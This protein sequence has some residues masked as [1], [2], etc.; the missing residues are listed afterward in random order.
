MALSGADYVFNQIRVGGLEARR[1]DE[2]FPDELGIPGEE[3][4]G[5]GGFANASR[6]IPIV[7]EYARL[8]ERYCP[9][10]TLLTLTNPISLVQYAITRYTHI[11]TIGLCDAPVTLKTNLAKALKVPIDELFMDYVGMHHFGW[12]TGIWHAGK[13][14]MPQVLEKAA[15]IN[16]EVEP[17]IVQ[18]FGAIPG[19]YYNYLFHSDRMLARKKGKR[20]RAEELLEI[21]DEILEDYDRVLV[22]G[23]RPASLARRNARWYKAIVT[24]VLLALIESQ[25]PGFR[26]GFTSPGNRFILNISNGEIIPWLPHEAIIEVS[27]IIESGRVRPLAIGPVSPAVKTLIQSNCAYEMLA[28]EAIVERDRSKALRALLLNP[29]IHTYDQA[30]AVLERA[31]NNGDKMPS[32]VYI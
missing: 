15:E 24:P 11:N 16:P 13:D 8:I 18:A 5:P 25:Q 28:V 27:S 2:S 26:S 4:V 6:T 20:T 9:S 22:T 3:T 19:G 30:N 23:Q 29:M 17:A 12:V 32:K 1:F 31:W 10:V 21:Q 7:L 14:L